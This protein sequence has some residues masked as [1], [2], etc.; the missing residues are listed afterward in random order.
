[1]LL[2]EAGE[3][4]AVYDAYAAGD[5]GNA[6]LWFCKEQSFGFLYPEAG[7]PGSEIHAKFAQAVPVKLERG[8]TH[9]LC[10]AGGM[11]VMKEVLA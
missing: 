9:G 8:D 2:E 5:D 10:A 7:A 11:R 4:A 6:C 1:M 3:V